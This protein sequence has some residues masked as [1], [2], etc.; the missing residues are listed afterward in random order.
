MRY[1]RYT[2]ATLVTLCKCALHP[3]SL[4]FNSRQITSLI[5]QTEHIVIFCN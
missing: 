1:S 4:S 5:K 2:V 3:S